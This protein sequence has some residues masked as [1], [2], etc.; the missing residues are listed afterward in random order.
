[1]AIP[2]TCRR[3]SGWVIA[4]RIRTCERASLEIPTLRSASG[5]AATLVAGRRDLASHRT[6]A[7][8]E[9]PGPVHVAVRPLL[10][11][12]GADPGE[13]GDRR[14]VA[15][16]QRARP[17]QQPAA[18]QAGLH[19]GGGARG[20]GARQRWTCLSANGYPLP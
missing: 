19:R 4:S 2:A 6:A 18:A 13:G 12:P 11:G 14:R 17:G 8:G 15:G 1:L 3:C 5:T 7:L 10:P 16:R 20:A 9:A